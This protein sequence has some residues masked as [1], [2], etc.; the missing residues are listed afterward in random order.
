MRSLVYTALLNLQTCFKEAADWNGLTFIRQGYFLEF[1]LRDLA[2]ERG[3]YTCSACLILTLI[4]RSAIIM[5]IGN[6]DRNSS[7]LSLFLICPIHLYSVNRLK[8]LSLVA[9]STD[10]HLEDLLVGLTVE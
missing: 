9:L 10:S 3:S 5:F 8:G 7:D 6:N 1:A 2:R 4:D